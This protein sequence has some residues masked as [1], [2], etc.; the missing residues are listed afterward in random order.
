MFGFFKDR[1]RVKPALQERPGK[2][3]IVPPMPPVPVNTSLDRTIQ[4]AATRIARSRGD[5]APRDASTAPATPAPAPPLDPVRRCLIP[6]EC[7]LFGA[8]FAVKFRQNRISSAWFLDGV[9][10]PQ[11]AADAGGA[12]PEVYNLETLPFA[13]A[14]CPYCNKGMPVLCN[15][16][17][18]L[19]CRGSVDEAS[20]HFRCRCGSAGAMTPE[21]RT[22]SGYRHDAPRARLPSPS[23]STGNARLP[24]SAVPRIADMRERR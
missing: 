21:L 17:Q 14:R 24:P 18:R 19:C 13:A 11:G 1:T 9:V 6:V 4:T 2:D 16:C 22:V 20:Q 3:M 12:G 5:V 10:I 8:P 7:S 23:N 15:Q